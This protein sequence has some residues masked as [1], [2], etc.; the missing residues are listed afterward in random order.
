MFSSKTSLFQ[1]VFMLTTLT[2]QA[3]MFF[4]NGLLLQANTVTLYIFYNTTF[5][6]SVYLLFMYFV[7]A[8]K[9]NKKDINFPA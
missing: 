1:S 3:V 9:T 6:D 8:C 4:G 7:I 5:S 2:L